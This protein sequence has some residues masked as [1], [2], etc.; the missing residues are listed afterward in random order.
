M[1]ASRFTSAV[2]TLAAIVLLGVMP[3]VAVGGPVSSTPPTASAS[4][5]ATPTAALNDINSATAAQ[6]K[7]LPGIGDAYSAAIIKGR[8]YANKTQLK[9]R[10]I[11]PTATYNKIVSQIIANQPKK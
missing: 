7:T 8:P 9:T 3:A 6:L 10:N 4:P 2:L 5:S 1:K 11:I